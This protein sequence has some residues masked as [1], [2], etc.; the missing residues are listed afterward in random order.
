MAPKRK[1][2]PV[3]VEEPPAK[4]PTPPSISPP[5]QTM[6]AEY[7]QFAVANKIF[8]A[9]L[10]RFEEEGSRLETHPMALAS[11]VQ[12]YRTL[13]PRVTALM[14]ADAAAMFM[15]IR[16]YLET[17][18]AQTVQSSPVRDAPILLRH[19]EQADC[20][21]R[22]GIERGLA[23]LAAGKARGEQAMSRY[24]EYYSI[25]M[26]LQRALLRLEFLT[27]LATASGSGLT[28]AQVTQQCI[29]NV[30]ARYGL[31]A[32]II[33]MALD[34]GSLVGV[35][36]AAVQSRIE[37][38]RAKLG[39]M[40]P[41]PAAFMP[42]RYPLAHR[43]AGYFAEHRSPYH[44]EPMHRVDLAQRAHAGFFP[45][46]QELSRDRLTPALGPL[47]VWPCSGD[48]LAIH[49]EYC[50]VAA[51]ADGLMPLAEWKASRDRMWP[52]LEFSQIARSIYRFLSICN[53][54][55]PCM[56]PFR[57]AM[58]PQISVR[59]G[60]GTDPSIVL[61]PWS[62]LSDRIVGDGFWSADFFVGRYVAH[63]LSLSPCI[64]LPPADIQQLED[65]KT[66]FSESMLFAAAAQDPS[67]G[68]RDRYVARYEAYAA[69][70][71]PAWLLKKLSIGWSPHDMTPDNAAAPVLIPTNT[72]SHIKIPGQFPR[73]KEAL[74]ALLGMMR[75][76]LSHTHLVLPASI[77]YSFSALSATYITVTLDTP[78]VECLSPANIF[79]MTLPQLR[80]FFRPIV[81]VVHYLHHIA[82]YVLPHQCWA[83]I[84]TAMAAPGYKTP[85]LVL[86]WLA[87]HVPD[88]ARMAPEAAAPTPASNLWDLGIALAM[89]TQTGVV[90][91]P[92]S[93]GPH[94]MWYSSARFQSHPFLKRLY[95]PYDVHID[96]ASV[97]WSLLSREPQHRGAVHTLLYG[98]PLFSL[99]PSSITKHNS[100][101]GAQAPLD[102]RY[103]DLRNALIEMMDIS[104]PPGETDYPRHGIK[105][106]RKVA[107]GDV[108]MAK[109]Y[110]VLRRKP[111]FDNWKALLHTRF[112]VTFVDRS[113]TAGGAKKDA[114]VEM[115]EG[116]GVEREMWKHLSR[117]IFQEAALF[118][119]LAPNG[120]YVPSVWP[121]SLSIVEDAQRYADYAMI[122][123]LL[124]KR[125]AA[126]SKAPFPLARYIVK[127]FLDSESDGHTTRLDLTDLLQVDPDLATQL[128]DMHFYTDA[129]LAEV[130]LVLPGTDT[131]VASQGD[132]RTFIAHQLQETLVRPYEKA[133][134]AMK[135]GFCYYKTPVVLLRQMFLLP[136]AYAIVTG[137]HDPVTPADV[138]LILDI[139]ESDPPH[140]GCKSI[141]SHRRE[142]SAEWGVADAHLPCTTLLLRQWVDRHP[143]LCEAFVQFCTGSPGITINNEH[144]TVETVPPLRDKP[145]ALLHGPIE[146]CQLPSTHTCLRR[147]YMP[148][149]T[150]WARYQY[151]ASNGTRSLAEL[152]RELERNMDR[153]MELALSCHIFDI[154]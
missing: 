18:D 98:T 50:A 106:E 26:E 93:A 70:L 154:K 116:L 49:L 22:S 29:S 95:P 74:H 82:Q 94:L 121:P 143:E 107:T 1:V 19:I 146:R 43:L 114:I 34:G 44:T 111:I 62:L 3:A 104:I 124:L 79:P 33:A 30:S 72:A 23:S 61:A 59:T 152:A 47:Y 77:H 51:E 134:T 63:I 123:K 128:I 20:N 52:L 58:H 130:C 142:R 38:L 144:I 78:M 57:D 36:R 151:H 117:Y 12:I 136:E 40:A 115:G 126:N 100:F 88:P 80:E 32:P 122:G 31:P 89:Y 92:Q 112:W 69:H 132:L 86:P 65:Q 4:H 129:E 99:E 97:L 55:T 71:E 39:A 42:D 75:H 67:P 8:L 66:Q 90:G 10:E 113:M 101:G 150:E 110:A 83:G 68:A 147:I 133:I 91:L 28:T 87:I 84:G 141:E 24:R 21:Y 148:N 46:L 137:K 64:Q 37:K 127:I 131:V 41:L 73:L 139:P 15:R 60:G 54:H 120:I 13:W 125:L 138:Q 135:A 108:N 145:E 81:H 27:M 103:V 76:G 17:S 5:I 2:S 149:Y 118:Q 53:K 109:A 56:V 45:L 9:D 96:V 105:I 35:E 14:R 102:M 140:R 6:L 85:K 25:D 119:S 48:S 7:R 153:V 16:T 11:H